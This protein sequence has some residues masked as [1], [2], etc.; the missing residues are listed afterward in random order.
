MGNAAIAPE[1]SHRCSLL[2]E[3]VIYVHMLAPRIVLKDSRVQR[4]KNK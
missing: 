4:N 3:Q 2:N 1:A